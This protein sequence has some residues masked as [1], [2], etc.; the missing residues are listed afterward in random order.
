MT[1]RTADWHLVGYDRDPVP[2]TMFDVQDVAK[3][4]SDRGA[5]MDEAAATLKSLADLEGWTGEAA[6]K[7]AEKAGEAHS[8]LGKASEKYTDAG[9]ALSTYAEEVNDAR[10]ATWKA[11]QAAEQAE[12][13]R[14]NNQT[15][16]LKDVDDPSDDLKDK[17]EQR[18]KDHTAAVGA[19]DQA[20]KDLEAAMTALGTAASNAAS[21]I[22]KASEKFKDSKMDNIKGFVAA[23]IDVLNVIAIVILAVIVIVLIVATCGG[24]LGVVLAAGGLIAT[25]MTIGTVVG[26]AILALTI[27]Q[28]AMGEG[29]LGD[30]ALASLGVI[31]GPLGKIGGKIAAP[32]L[33]RMATLARSTAAASAR[34]SLSFR[35]AGLV[36]R[37]PIGPLRTGLANFRQGLVDDAIAGVDNALATLPKAG[38]IAELNGLDGALDTMRNLKALSGMADQL[39]ANIRAVNIA[40]GVHATGGAATMAGQGN[41]IA[42]FGDSV[43]NTIDNLQNLPDVF[44]IDA[45]DRPTAIVEVG[46]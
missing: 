19:L 41:D 43:G 36:Q 44:N 13:D 27:V 6:K 10:L 33:A 9:S 15:S 20:K 34:G 8:D 11:V 5:V 42:G 31:G 30:I 37:I 39:P 29:D 16:L 38:I 32:A 3:D 2:A 23:A 25:L 21:R 7:F 45:P 28:V 12:K 1:R 14:L 4:F 46:R 22:N 35:I 24:F 26:A 40:I 18:D 17:D